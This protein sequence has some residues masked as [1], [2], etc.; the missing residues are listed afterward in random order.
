MA[1][2]AYRGLGDDLVHERGADR[3]FRLLMTPA[4]T[5]RMATCVSGDIGSCAVLPLGGH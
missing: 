3:A 1:G 4:V 2:K 5:L